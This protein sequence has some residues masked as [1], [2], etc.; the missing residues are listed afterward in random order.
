[1]TDTPAPAPQRSSQSRRGRFLALAAIAAI[2]AV[3]TFLA[4]ALL[5][6]IFTRKQEARHPFVRLVE[7]DENTTDPS[8]W[9]TNWPRQYDSYRRTVDY[10]RTRYGG[11]DAIPEQKLD[12]SPWLRLMYSGYA[13]AI[14]YREARG[15][16][17]MLLDQEQTQR[18]TKPQ[19]GAC[20]HCHASVIP[21]YRA[22]GDGDVWAGFAKINAM[23]YNEARNLTD[24]HGELL[25]NHPVSCV[26]CHDPS[27]MALRV[28]R[29]AFIDGIRRLKAS[30]G[31]KDYDVNRDATRQEMRTY[32]CAQCHVEYYF[33]PGTT[34]LTYP[35]SKGILAEQMEAYYDEIGFHDWEHGI[36]GAKVLKAQHPEFEIW[37][38]GA[39]ARAG[40]SCADCHMPYERQ[41]A[42][43]VTNHHVRSPLLNVA[44]SCQV[45]HNA[46]EDELIARAHTIQDRTVHLI[47]LAAD[48][49]VDM[50]NAIA[51]AKSAG[52]TDEQLEEARRL[53]RRAQ[54]RLDLV[55]SENSHGF[56]ASQE[57]ARLLAEAIDFARQGEVAARAI[58]TPPVE[59]P[60]PVERAPVE[61][62]T[63]ADR[64]PPGPYRDPENPRGGS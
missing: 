6:N 18:Q 8:V 26:D 22:V 29:P 15:H 21:A 53:H 31:I 20:L 28:T 25:I 62:V 9:G 55:S 11:S 19:P 17:Y 32:A 34:M 13:F 14:D 40:V 24:E 64:A 3:G 38:Q 35:W 42:L 30:Q 52:A 10:V 63:P 46:P 44:A 23:P 4:A 39:H 47:D 59:D 56:H 5:V 57:T 16:A 61:G 2:A 36:T 54:F 49:L 12:R 51:E 60:L 7:V 27:T 58:R 41:G 43:K 37:S 33:A 45:C 48:A 1:M 50:I